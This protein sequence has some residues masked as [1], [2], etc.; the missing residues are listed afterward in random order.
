MTAYLINKNLCCYYWLRQ[1]IGKN[2][3]LK[4]AR[5]AE[6]AIGIFGRERIRIE[7]IKHALFW[8]RGH[9]HTWTLIA[10]SLLSA[11]NV[12]A[13]KRLSG[14]LVST[15]HLSIWSTNS[16]RN[17]PQ[18]SGVR[19]VAGGNVQRSR[20]RSCSR[21]DDIIIVVCATDMRDGL[22]Y[23]QYR[24]NSIMFTIEIFPL[25]PVS[26]ISPRF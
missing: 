26:H 9:W 13:L 5:T 19:K 7:P 24:G 16:I 20:Y 17:T 1:R 18:S 4:L 21:T 12:V 8:I 23:Y 25:E 6:K 3:A 14:W 22:L 15:I 11:E 10:I 2:R